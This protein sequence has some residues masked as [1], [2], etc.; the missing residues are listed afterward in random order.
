MQLE[1][2]RLFLRRMTADDFE[3][4]VAFYSDD[5]QARYLG[6]VKT[7]QQAAEFMKARVLDYYDA[8]PGLGMW[9]TVEG[10][11][12]DRVG[13]HLINNIQG[14]TIIQIGYGLVKQAWGKGYATEMAS[15]LM[16]YAFEE[17][18]LPTMGGIVSLPNVAS[19]RVL[20]KIGL[21]RRGE[22]SFAHPA[23]ASIN[24]TAW[25]EIERDAWLTHHRRQLSQ[26]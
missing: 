16:R 19:Q 17:L 23:Y 4:L 20:T 22:R 11:T 26:A 2:E 7:R 5:E 9:M 21:E 8:N 6:G 12:G 3:W 10:A 18:K 13:F 15:A 14:E 1:T 24:P 25:F